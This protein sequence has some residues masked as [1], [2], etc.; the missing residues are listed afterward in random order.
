MLTKD[1]KGSIDG[2]I[3]FAVF[4]LS[5]IGLYVVFSV[6]S[7]IKDNM[8][9]Y[10]IHQS[11]RLMIGIT[12]LFL[13][14]RI[15]YHLYLR[16]GLP[17]LMISFIF[18][19]A[20]IFP[21]LWSNGGVH[22]WIRLLFFNFQ[23]SELAKLSLIIFLADFLSRKQKNIKSF[24]SVFFPCLLFIGVT[25]FL[26][27]VEPD[28]GTAAAIVSISM[29]LLFLGK[30]PLVYLGGLLIGVIPVFYYFVVRSSYRLNRL[31]AFLRPDQDL[32]GKNYQVNQSLISLGKGGLWG[33]GVGQGSQK[34]FYLPEAHTDFVFS[35]LGEELGFIGALVVIILFIAFLIR[36]IKIAKAAPDLFGFLLT[37]GIVTMI[38]LY[39]IINIA[40]VSSLLPNKGLPLP[41]IS[42]GGSAMLFNMIGIGIL[43]N[44][45]RHIL[46]KE[47]KGN[48]NK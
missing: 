31:L 27:V 42:F 37:A 1:G 38:T 3:L 22:R 9:F 6:G 36:G 14:S 43:L 44:I 11:V 35:V 23:P 39:G 48:G 26:I 32:L 4:T 41:F 29:I 25:F 28:F 8:F 45:S 47:I 33:E 12:L 34:I 16:K 13:F 17:F 2:I 30:I 5:F 46:P 10:L 7:V 15:D 18:L 40:V 21:K 24:S 20:V 19:I